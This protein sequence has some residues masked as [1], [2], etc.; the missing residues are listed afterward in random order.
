MNF[1]QHLQKLQNKEQYSFSRWGDGEWNCLL[2]KQGMNCDRHNYFDDL[3]KRLKSI[4]ESS[5]QY[6]LGLQN[7]AKRQ[8][9]ELIDKYTKD[10]NLTWVQND[11]LHTASMKGQ[12]IHFLN[13]LRGLDVLLVGGNH[14]RDFNK[15][16]RFI[17]IPRVNC[18]LSYEETKKKLDVAIKDNT[19]VLFCASM[20]T[21][22]LIDDFHGRGTL[23]DLGS[24]LDPYCGVQSRSYH[25]TLDINV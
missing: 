21:N 5:P 6:Y 20:M 10:Y 1:N 2:G 23:I 17:E 24:V 8:R 14:L 22:V 15:S 19:V 11:V 3:G 16:W 4:L 9:P 25:K 12:F 18:W 7:L 13:V